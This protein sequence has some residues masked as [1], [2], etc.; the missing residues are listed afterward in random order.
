MAHAVELLQV[1]EHLVS[2]VADG[3]GVSITTVLAA[4]KLLF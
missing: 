2:A 4:A 3:V 1:E